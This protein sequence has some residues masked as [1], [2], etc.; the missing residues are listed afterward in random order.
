[1]II[2]FLCAELMLQGIALNFVA[3]SRFRGNLHGQAFVLFI[4]AVA[5][6]EAA[7][8]LSLIL[9]LYKR[10]ESLDISLWQDLREPNQEP[11]IDEEPLPPPE[12][13]APLPHLI[14]AGREPGRKQEASH[15]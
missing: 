13:Q 5:A 11:T 1:M 9:M 6:C 14:P 12:K 4:L 7:I 10:K 3:F 2:L 8:A 15:V